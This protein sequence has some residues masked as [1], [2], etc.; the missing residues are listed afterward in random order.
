M[1]D[2]EAIAHATQDA[3]GGGGD[4]RGSA[5]VESLSEFEDVKKAVGSPGDVDG[6]G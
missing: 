6:H 3:P 1:T 5:V 2:I 4:S